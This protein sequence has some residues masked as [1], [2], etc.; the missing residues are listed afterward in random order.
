M[1]E[2]FFFLYILVVH[3]KVQFVE[4][5]QHLDISFKNTGKRSPR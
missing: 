5:S 4:S 1:L 3:L 2:V